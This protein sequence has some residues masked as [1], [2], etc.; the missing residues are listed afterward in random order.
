MIKTY[1]NKGTEDLHKGNFVKKFS[2]IANVAERKLVM[3]AA[4]TV[5]DDLRVP[6]ANRLE[7]LSGNRK[8]QHSIRI[9][10]QYRVCFN[11]RNGNAYNVEVVDYH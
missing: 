4:A 11:F 10:D 9:N 3:L 7:A 2:A 1:K 8:G 5:L 6:P